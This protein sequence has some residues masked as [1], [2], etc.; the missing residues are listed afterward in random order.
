M[1]LVFCYCSKCLSGF[2]G[3]YTGLNKVVTGWVVHFMKSHL[4]L[5]HTKD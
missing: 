4:V 2:I 5:R 3:D 1:D